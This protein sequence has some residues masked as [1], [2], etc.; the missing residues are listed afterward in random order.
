MTRSPWVTRVAAA[1]SIVVGATALAG[2]IL[3]RVD[4]QSLFVAPPLTVKTNTAVGMIAA[5]IALW[6]ASAPSPRRNTIVRALAVLVMAIG[7]ATLSEHVM[8]WD[9]GI[10]QLLFVETPGSPATTRPNRMGPPAST[11]YFLLGLSLFLL[12]ARRRG[13]RRVGRAA[14]ILVMGIALLGIMGY[15]THASP[16][17]AAGRITGIAL[18]T[19]VVLLALAVGIVAARPDRGIA[20][21]LSRND[22]AGTL[23]RRLIVPSIILPLLMAVA[24][25]R[26]VRAG[27]FDDR[28]ATA[29]MALVVTIGLTAVIWKTAADL[30]R[31]LQARDAAEA[32]SALREE[33]TRVVNER[34]RE[35]LAVLSHELRNPLAPMRYALER[36]GPWDGAGSPKEVIRR[37]LAHLVRLVDDLLDVTRVTTGRIVLRKQPV[38]VADVFL[39]SVEATRPDL[40][41]TGHRLTVSLPP[42]PIWIDADVDRVVQVVTNLLNNAT[43]Y[44]PAGGQIT[45]A[46]DLDDGRLRVSVADTGVGLAATD[47][48]SVFEMF[49]QVGG[50]GTAGLGIGLAI[51]KT[52]VELHGGR[53][54]A[55]SDGLGKGAEFLFWLARVPAPLVTASPPPA[56][57]ARRGRKVVV[58]DD[59]EDSAEMMRALLEIDGHEVEVAFDGPSAVEL[60]GRVR[61]HAAV[62]DIGMPGLDGYEV[63]RRVRAGDRAIFLIAVTGWGQDSDRVRAQ[64][65]G[66]DTHL[67]KPAD[68]DAIRKLLAA[69]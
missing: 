6:L 34:Q 35:F 2:W 23:A 36:P 32:Q 59:N 28:F 63:A 53:V 55:R 15:A 12:D 45:L 5:G 4:L 33:A 20:A 10:D 21:L 56:V 30:S 18:V 69:L 41:R 60:I 51:V 61:P 16:L 9:L 37:Q 43:R 26:A 17:Y 7:G 24:L 40:E 11:S 42:D 14:A 31:A 3:D 25:T 48:E 39:Q 29:A 50:P 8:G 27:W 22:E 13:A 49:N 68:P 46:A 66:F 38:A 19:A 52:I 47:L 57:E 58:A 65:A 1:G 67:T 44:T 54:E 62:L 64:D